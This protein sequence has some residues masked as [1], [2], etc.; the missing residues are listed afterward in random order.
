MVVVV[1]AGVAPA[2]PQ[3]QFRAV[4]PKAVTPLP[5]FM[6]SRW[7]ARCH[8]KRLILSYPFLGF[9]MFPGYLL[10]S[11]EETFSIIRSALPSRCV[12]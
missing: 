8:N 3:H 5:R 9:K 12:V 11:F 4:R 7:L 10:G 1:A 6:K 2:S